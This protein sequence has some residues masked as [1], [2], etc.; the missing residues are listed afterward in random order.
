MRFD[1]PAFTTGPSATNVGVTFR[2]RG[3]A[4]PGKVTLRRDGS[5]AKTVITVEGLTGRVAIQ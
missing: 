1:S 4:T 2:S 3:T 5:S